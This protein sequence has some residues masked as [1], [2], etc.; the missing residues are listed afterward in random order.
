MFTPKIAADLCRRSGIGRTQFGV[1]RSQPVQDFTQSGLVKPLQ[2]FQAVDRFLPKFGRS[3]PRVVRPSA[4]AELGAL[5]MRCMFRMCAHRVVV[6]TCA[7]IT[8]YPPRHDA[9]KV[10]I[11]RRRQSLWIVWARPIEVPPSPHFLPHKGCAGLLHTHTCWVSQIRRGASC[12]FGEARSSPALFR[13]AARIIALAAP[14]HRAWKFSFLLFI[15]YR[16]ACFTR[17]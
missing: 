6:R 3:R 9:R 2:H 1:G 10:H 16:Y 14:H 17:I 5:C 7:R 11:Q 4:C 8:S 15:G 12:R 13:R